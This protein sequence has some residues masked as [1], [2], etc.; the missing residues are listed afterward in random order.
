RI[1]T[2]LL[3]EMG[4]RPDVE[5]DCLSHLS[6]REKVESLNEHLRA[7]LECRT[8]PSTRF[9]S[10]EDRRCAVASSRHSGQSCTNT[11]ARST[12]RRARAPWPTA[13]RPA[14]GPAAGC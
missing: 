5:P 11:A 8:S 14:P 6:S 12:R 9:S 13:P 2:T 7:G 10:Q 3:Y 1:L 4:R